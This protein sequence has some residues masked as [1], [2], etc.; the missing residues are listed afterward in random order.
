MVSVGYE[1]PNL[2]VMT[3]ATIH[4]ARLGTASDAPWEFVG[5][6]D[7][8]LTVTAPAYGGTVGPVIEASGTITGTDENFNCRCAKVRSRRW[9]ATSAVSDRRQ[10]LALVRAS[11]DN[12]DAA[13]RSHLGRLDRRTRPER[14]DVRDY[15]RANGVSETMTTAEVATYA[16]G[17]IDQARTEWTPSRNRPE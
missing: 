1:L 10:K 11:Y 2:K 17:Q 14:R 7:N 9:L 5:T 6:E 12:R 3:A 16:Y 15:R 13:W 4:L 8:M